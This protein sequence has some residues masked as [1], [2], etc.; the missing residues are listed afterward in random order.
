MDDN[1]RILVVDD[2]QV[3][4]LAIRRFLKAA[5]VQAELVEADNCAAALASLQDSPFDL[6]FIDYRLPDGDGLSLVQKIQRQ[7][8]QTPLVVLTGQGDEQTAVQLMKAGASDYILK[9]QMSAETIA[10]IIRNTMRL[11]QAEQEAQQATQKLRDSEERYRLVVEGS[12]DGIW[13]WDLIRD[14]LY[15]NDRLLEIVGLSRDEFGGKGQDFFE[16]LHPA[17]RGRVHQAVEAHLAQNVPYNQEFRLRHVSG[18]YRYCVARGKSQRDTQGHPTRMSGILSDITERKLARQAVAESEERFRTMA[19]SAPVLLW[20]VDRQGQ[21]SF[22]N[23]AWLDFTGR[24]LPQ[25]LENGWL[26][27]LHPEDRQSYLQAY[28]AA[29]ESHQPFETEYRLRRADGEY[30]WILA[31]D[32]PR[33]MP[34]SRFVGY[35]GSGIDITERKR[36]EETQRFLAEASRLLATSLDYRVTLENLAQFVVPYLADYCIVDMLQEDQSLQQVAVAHGQP[37]NV[38]LVRKLH[39]LHPFNSNQDYGVA[40]VLR[41]GQSELRSRI[42]QELLQ[43]YATDAEHLQL[44]QA[45]NP[46]SYIVSP[47]IARGRILGA[48]SFLSAESGRIYSP[49]NL[50]LTEDLTQRA[51]LAVDNARL[52]HKSQESSD[53]LRKAIIVLGEQQQQLRAL[54]QLTN[55]LNQRLTDLPGLLQLMVE[56][57]C[58]ALPQAEFCLI[59]LYNRQHRVLELTAA[60]GSGTEQLSNSPLFDLAAGTMGQVFQTG[61]SQLVQHSPL[62]SHFPTET[63]ASL[64]AVPIQSAQAVCLGVLAVGNWTHADAFDEE[65]RILMIAFGEQ[66][67]I[68]LNNAQ[69]INALEEREERLATQNQILAQQNRELD[70]QRQQIQLQ[71]LKLIEATQLKSQFLATMS[72]ELRTPINA[73]TGFSQLLLRQRQSELNPRQ[74]DMIERI[75]NNGKNLLTLINDILDLSKIEAGRMELSLE[76][77][78][79]QVLI[80]ETMAE[81]RS[82]AEQKGLFLKFE[83]TL[84]NPQ[85]YNDRLRL[86]QILVNLISNAIKF[87][88]TGGVT[89]RLQTLESDWI[90]IQVQDTGVGIGKNHLHHIFDEFWQADQTTTRRHAGTGL[91]LAITA[92]LVRMMQGQTSVESEVD[93]GSTFRVQIPRQ[94]DIPAPIRTA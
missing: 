54:Q 57:V 81:L 74:A 71:N 9:E 60:T 61:E 46:K 58:T 73:I 35:I 28:H 4:R 47:L 40:R 26:V 82:L 16:L 14:R 92:R 79:L 84:Q 68:A 62:D 22:F 18:A 8:I 89:L 53:N 39:R 23:Q 2:D 19:D 42:S 94:V 13:D 56:A 91:G 80:T 64:C 67:A 31:T 15:W 38:E 43:T 25:E 36:S 45:L 34:D 65:G 29:F 33:W 69:L 59:A 52:Y 3:D 87:T 24:S 5:N 1:L 77:F 7:K 75:L 37:A 21:R 93:Q 63:M 41:T 85:A 10:Q 12:G 51:A 66:A 49:A 88:E 90:E 20:L 48:I 32:T 55:L 44:L 76:G 86:R 50:P 78:D 11:Y 6:V 17:D 72:H 83:G 27:S 70:H 30:R